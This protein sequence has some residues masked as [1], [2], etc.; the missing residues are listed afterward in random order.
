MEHLWSIKMTPEKLEKCINLYKSGTTIK[1]IAKE[2]ELSPQTI[3]RHLK[4][5]GIKPRGHAQTKWVNDNWLD[6]ID[7]EEK[8][9]FLGFFIAD[10]CIR[11]EKDKRGYADCYRL[12]FS[13][14]IDDREIIEFIHNTLCPNHTMIEFHNSRGAINRKPQ[15]LLQ[16]SSPHLIE[17]LMNDFKILPRKTH[18][19]N[20]SFPWE[21]IPEEYYKDFLRGFLDGDG[22]ITT[23]HEL[24]WAFNS[25]IFL[26]EYVGVLEKLYNKIS[27][28]LKINEPFTYKYT[29]HQGK[30]VNYWMLRVNMGKKRIP[31]FKNLF[32]KDAKLYLNRKYQKLIV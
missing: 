14:S 21:K 31:I 1:E 7:C 29:K 15:L 23:Q 24:R 5:H 4:K 30:T 6:I 18:D 28:K 9:Y 11:K 17:V 2:V 3:S 10:G 8:A 20:F 13:N 19:V 12:T 22:S 26:K 32:Y 16:W 27:K 25:E